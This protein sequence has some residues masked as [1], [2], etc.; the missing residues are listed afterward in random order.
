M[1]FELAAETEVNI[2]FMFD[3]DAVDTPTWNDITFSFSDA[4]PVL[5]P[6]LINSDNRVN[7]W[8]IQLI[9]IA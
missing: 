9:R 1:C 8:I 3:V 2:G 6:I 4:Q 5:Y 7:D